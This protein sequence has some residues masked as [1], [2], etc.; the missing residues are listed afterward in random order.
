[1]PPTRIARTAEHLGAAGLVLIVAAVAFVMGHWVDSANNPAMPCL[2]TQVYVW[3]N[4]PSEARCV[5]ATDHA[6]HGGG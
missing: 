2:Q 5:D 3:S 4:Y 1:M 6:H